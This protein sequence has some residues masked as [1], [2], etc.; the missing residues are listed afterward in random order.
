MDGN[1]IGKVKAWALVSGLLCVLFYLLHDIVGAM[2][3]PGYDPMCQAVSDLTAVDAPSFAV[4]SGYSAVYGV[5]SCLCCAMLCM[6]TT[7]ERRE[8]RIG[9]RLFTVMNMVSAIGYSLFPLTSGGYDGS[10]Q[11]FVHVYVLTALVVLLSIASSVMLSIGGS[12]DGRKI[13]SIISI[14]ALLCMFFGAVGTSVFP[15]EFFG[16]VERFS[17]YS[18]V[19]FIGFL[20]VYWYI[21]GRDGKSAD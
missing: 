4:A 15:E 2:N 10:F 17:T 3:Y 20:G 13:L 14:I 21:D 11:S 6:I 5:F 18:A 19:I 9:I 1:I 7:N 8:L 16:L 12:R